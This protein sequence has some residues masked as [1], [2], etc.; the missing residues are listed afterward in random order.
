MRV[1]HAAGGTLCL[2]IVIAATY[3]FVLRGIE[4][5]VEDAQLGS[6][7]SESSLTCGTDQV[8]DSACSHIRC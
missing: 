1:Y 6:T 3:T 5:L 8:I 7:C 4:A 2:P